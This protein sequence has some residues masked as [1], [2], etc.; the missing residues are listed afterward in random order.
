M[1]FS[2][3]LKLEIA[4]NYGKVTIA[5]DYKYLNLMIEND[6]IDSIHN[7]EWTNVSG[8]PLPM[9]GNEYQL[10]TKGQS[11]LLDFRSH[12]VTRTMACVAL[13]FSFISLWISIIA[14]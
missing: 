2:I 11:D 8:F 9:Y 13:F 1:N 10:T 12:L 14:L 3:F 5:S 7:G 6:W 4:N